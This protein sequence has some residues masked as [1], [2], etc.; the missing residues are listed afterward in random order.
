MDK[1]DFLYLCIL[2]MLTHTGRECLSPPL[3][4]VFNR[5]VPMSVG[6]TS[7]TLSM[8]W[9]KPPLSAECADVFSYPPLNY[10]ITVAD[11]QINPFLFAPMVSFF[12]TYYIVCRSTC[13]FTACVPL[14][15]YNVYSMD[16]CYCRHPI[17]TH[18]HRE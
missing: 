7:T 2:L 3:T 1:N 11:P 17:H 16:C 14:L 15:S 5:P 13:T 9:D 4:E 10:V 8:E 6:R 18:T 12:Q